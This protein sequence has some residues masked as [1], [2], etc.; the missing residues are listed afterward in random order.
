VSAAVLNGS[1]LVRGRKLFSVP[2]VELRKSKLSTPE[3]GNVSLGMVG[4]LPMMSPLWMMMAGLCCL[5]SGVVGILIV[6]IH[7]I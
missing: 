3:K 2:P 1:S 4:L 5:V 6:S 7:L